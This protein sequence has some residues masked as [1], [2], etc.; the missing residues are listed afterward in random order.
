MEF[1]KCSLDQ[2][3]GSWFWDGI[4]IVPQSK[5]GPKAT[6]WKANYHTSRA[7]SNILF[8]LKSKNTIH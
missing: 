2:E 6:I 5:L 4:D 8:I 1:K 3:F 7:L